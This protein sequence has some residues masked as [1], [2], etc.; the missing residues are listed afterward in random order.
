[1]RYGCAMSSLQFT[2]CS[3]MRGSTVLWYSSKS[4]PSSWLSTCGA[5]WKAR[6]CAWVGARRRHGAA[7][8]GF[9]R[10]GPAAPA[11]PSPGDP[12]T[13]PCQLV[14]KRHTAATAMRGAP[15]RVQGPGAACAPTACS[16]A[17]QRPRG[18]VS[19]VHRSSTAR[20][21]ARTSVKFC[22]MKSTASCAPH[23]CR[24]QRTRRARC[25]C[26]AVRACLHVAPLAL[27]L[28][29]RVRQQVLADLRQIRAQKQAPHGVLHAA[30]HLHLRAR[31]MARVRPERQVAARERPAPGPSARPWRRPPLT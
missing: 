6:C 5:A 14:H 21:C 17:M 19:W 26:A 31:R 30:R 22:R 29:A 28:R 25:A 9:Y 18:R 27:V 2:T 10:P 16:S 1:M 8:A 11:A 12:A 4:T 3:R 7:P 20:A 15:C 13:S 24:V 23:A